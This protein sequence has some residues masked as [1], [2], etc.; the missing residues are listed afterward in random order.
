MLSVEVHLKHRSQNIG[1]EI[2]RGY[3]LRIL[4]M[5]TVMYIEQKKASQK[6]D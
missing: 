1:M 4:T 2:Y 3:L 5:I 6:K